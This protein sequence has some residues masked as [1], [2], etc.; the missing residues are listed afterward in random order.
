MIRII[1]IL[2]EE[3]KIEKLAKTDK[4]LGVDLGIATFA[5]CSDGQMIENPKHLR[6][7]ESRLKKL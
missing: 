7:S 4:K 1:S 6:E 3:E 2:V 5:V